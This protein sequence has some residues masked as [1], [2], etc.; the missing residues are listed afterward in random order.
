MR[1]NLKVRR[2]RP[3][4]PHFFR[5]LV[6]VRAAFEPFRL[7]R[8]VYDRAPFFGRR[9]AR[10]S[11][12]KKDREHVGLERPGLPPS[13][14]ARRTWR[15]SRRPPPPNQRFRA[16]QGIRNCRIRA[17]RRVFLLDGAEPTQVESLAFRLFGNQYSRTRAREFL[18]GAPP[19]FISDQPQSQLTWKCVRPTKKF[20]GIL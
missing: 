15:R 3:P 6:G 4:R 17:G 7:Y 8:D 10:S 2:A 12:P 18:S 1:K 9:K 14:P 19:I 11:R 13:R 5:K 20:R 16:Y